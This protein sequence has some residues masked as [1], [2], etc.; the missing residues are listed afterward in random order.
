MK[1]HCN[2]IDN[3][4]NKKIYGKHKHRITLISTETT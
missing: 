3:E 1:F 2:E 4:L